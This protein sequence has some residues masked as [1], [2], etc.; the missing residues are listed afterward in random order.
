MN[1]SLRHPVIAWSLLAGYCLLMFFQSSL[2]SPDMGPDLPLQDKFAHLAAYAVMG[3]LACSAWATV[4]GL[5]GTFGVFLAGFL[6]AL[7]FGLSDEWHQSFVPERMADGWD[8]VADG[9][10]AFLGAGLYA[11]RCR[12]VDSL[13]K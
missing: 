6:F 12:R 1:L 3:F 9:V 8:L 10:G 13:V 4:P 7:L 5:R 2:P 11:W